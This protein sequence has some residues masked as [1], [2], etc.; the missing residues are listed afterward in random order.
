MS[1]ASEILA[2]SPSRFYKLNEASGNLIDYGSDGVN[3]TNVQSAPT[4]SV[5][6]GI[7]S[8]SDTAISYDGTD[9]T[10]YENSTTATGTP[11]NGSGAASSTFSHMC[12]VFVDAAAGDNTWYWTFGSSGSNT[13]LFGFLN[14][15]LTT[16]GRVSFWYR[17]S[18]S[19]NAELTTPTTDGDYR[20]SWHIVHV[21]SDGTTI[22]LYVDGAEKRN[23]AA[24]TYT[25]TS[26]TG[27]ATFNKMAISGLNRS[28]LGQYSK[29]KIQ[30]AA[31]FPTA[32]SSTRVTDHYNAFLSAGSSSQTLSLPTITDTDTLNVPTLS[33]GSV[34]LSLPTI[35]DTDSLFAPEVKQT[36][37]L[38]LINDSDTL[39]APAVTPGSV[40]LSLPTISSIST[41]S[42][43]T[44][45]TAAL[46]IALPHIN[47]VATTNTYPSLIFDIDGK[48]YKRVTSTKY[49]EV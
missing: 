35:N 1:L 16:N 5:T 22:R 12:V 30:Y 41:L 19:G 17:N 4:Y 13:P 23:G 7:P 43:P 8:S 24:G 29:V 26:S 18:A 45:A 44:V 21:T 49:M 36:L 14:R 47:D 48:A 31:F 37:V 34:S 27:G 33:P 32:L 38:P 25:A 10:H 28:T 40:T 3:I 2:D 20:G 42:S 11:V 15:N 6:G 9:D 39:N 46:A